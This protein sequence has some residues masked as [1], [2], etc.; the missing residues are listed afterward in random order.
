MSAGGIMQGIA[1]FANLI[2]VAGPF[3]AAGLS[4]AGGAMANS[5]GARTGTAAPTIAP[6]YQSLADLL[7]ARAMARLN[8]GTDM[9]GF[10][11]AG[12]NNINGA[13]SNAAV[14]TNAGLEAR[15]LA[16]SPVA[17]AVAGHANTARAASIAEFLN[18]VPLIQ[19][20]LQNEDMANATSQ[21]RNFGVG[22]RT[23]APGSAVAGGLDSAAKMLAFLRGSG[24][25]GAGGGSGSNPFGGID[26][27]GN[28]MGPGY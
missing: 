5:E 3:I 13:F 24:V 27:N 12:V 21:V 22:Q 23:V 19:R 9:G 1:P 25:L 2:P 10:K 7:K 20:Q 28:V 14:G 11:A 6:G 4:A 17:A 18:S 8:M 15:G 16:T 26:L